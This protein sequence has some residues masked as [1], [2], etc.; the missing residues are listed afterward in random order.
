MSNTF[1]NFYNSVLQEMVTNTQPTSGAPAQNTNQ[2]QQGQQTAQPNQQPA[3]TSNNQQY[4]KTPAP[5]AA[6]NQ[7]SND[8]DLMK[9]LQQKLQDEKF[10]QQLMQMLNNP[11][12]R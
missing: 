6:P 3:Q 12:K 11:V 8:N 5:N 10:K 4:Q 7:T 2:P 1:D 9:M